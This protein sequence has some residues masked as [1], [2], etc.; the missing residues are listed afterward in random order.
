MQVSGISDEC[1]I[2]KTGTRHVFFICTVCKRQLNSLVNLSP[3]AFKLKF[4][5]ENEIIYLGQT[6]ALNLPKIKLLISFKMPRNLDFRMT[7]NFSLFLRE[8]RIKKKITCTTITVS[9]E[10]ALKASYNRYHTQG[11]CILSH[12]HIYYF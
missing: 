5:K 12:M 8:K 7:K 11:S 2:M 1:H 9:L 3:F 4:K 6:K 10:H